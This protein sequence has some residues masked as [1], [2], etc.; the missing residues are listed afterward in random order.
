MLG[1]V[2]WGLNKIGET[3]DKKDSL[4]LSTDGICFIFAMREQFMMPA[5]NHLLIVSIKT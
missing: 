1:I 2:L 4:K 3:P 5:G